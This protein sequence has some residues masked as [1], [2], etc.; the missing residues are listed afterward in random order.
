M[1]VE[2]EEEEEE[3]RMKVTGEQRERGGVAEANQEWGQAGR[4]GGRRRRRMK[5]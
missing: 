3:D 5:T 4:G 1:G 2:K